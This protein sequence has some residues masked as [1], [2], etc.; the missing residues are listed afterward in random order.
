MTQRTSILTAICAAASFLALAGVFCGGLAQA[1]EAPT[2][3]NG[4]KLVPLK[5]EL[6]KPL[7]QGTPKNI[8]AS[9]DAGKIQ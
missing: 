9:R 1:A 3:P 7:F 4:E 6:P 8:K 2:G 5:I